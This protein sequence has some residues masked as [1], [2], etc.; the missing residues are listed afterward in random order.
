MSTLY[1]RTDPFLHA[2]ARPSVNSQKGLW[3]RNYAARDT[4][5]TR[6]TAPE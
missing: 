6:S 1:V 4:L 2:M 5:V 3:I